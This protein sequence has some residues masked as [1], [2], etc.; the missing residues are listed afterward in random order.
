MYL[1]KASVL[2]NHG[3]QIAKLIVHGF[4]HY[5]LKL[6]CS[7]LTELWHKARVTSFSSWEELIKGLPKDLSWWDHTCLI[8]IWMIC[9]TLKILMKF[10]ILQ[11]HNMS[12]LWQWSKYFD[13]DIR[14]WCSIGNRMVW[15]QRHE[16]NEDKHHLLVSGHKYENVWTKMPKEKIWEKAKQK[17]IGM[18]SSIFRAP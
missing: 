17:L 18:E 4:Q 13:H 9:F 11:M 12:C 6:Q 2:L 14:T 7:Y 10:L 16:L 5:A 15:K 1:S 8:C 3:L